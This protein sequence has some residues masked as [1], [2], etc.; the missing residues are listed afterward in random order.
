MSD[1]TSAPS[2]LAS[3]NVRIIFGSI[4]LAFCM[5]VIL[6]VVLKGAPGNSLHDSALSWAFMLIAAI[7][8]GFGVGTFAAP[9]LSALTVKK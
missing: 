9:L 3:W 8:G 5:Y 6:Y 1:E 7:L 2:T 4:V